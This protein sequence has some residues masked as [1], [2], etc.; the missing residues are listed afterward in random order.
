VETTAEMLNTLTWYPART[1]MTLALKH[2][3]T[4]EFARPLAWSCAEGSGQG[5]WARGSGS[6]AW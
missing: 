5:G 3:R 6:D 4:L 2:V 1:M